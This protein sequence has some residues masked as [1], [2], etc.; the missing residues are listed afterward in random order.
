MRFLLIAAVSLAAFLAAPPAAAAATADL[1]RPQYVCLNKAFPGGWV[2]NDPST[3]TQASID[4]ILAA[5]GGNRGS[6]SRKL[7]VS[8]NAWT[9][10]MSPANETTMLAS[11]DA[12]LALALANEL[13]LSIS[14]DPTQWWD[15]RP[16]LWNWYNKD[17]P[18]FNLNNVYNVEWTG[19]S[20]D[21]ATLISWR[22]WGA[23]F[24]LATPH[25]NFASP[26][27]RE[28][29]AASVAPLA[30]RVAAWYRALP[31]GKKWLL[32]Y[33]RATQELWIGTN[34]FYY[35]NG[36]ALA[37]NDPKDDPSG[38]PG[39]AAVQLGYA[40]VC[41]ASGGS[42]GVP[43]C[44]GAPGDGL[45][46]AQL[47]AVVSSFAAFAA[48]V[49]LDAGIP[50]SRVMV[51]TGAFFGGAPRCNTNCVFN[52]PQAAL[53]QG[54]NPAWSLYGAETSAA[55]NA[56]LP[57]ALGAIGGAA[58][59]ACEWL[60][61]FDAG[62]SESAWSN[63]FEST[64]SFLNNRLIVVQNF[65]SIQKDANATAAVAAVLGGQSCIVD[66]PTALAAN[67]EKKTVVISWTASPTCCVAS[68]ILIVSS[69]GLTLPD[70]IL[71]VPDV[72]TAQLGSDTTHYSLQLPAGV[73]AGE[74]FVQV[75]TYS[76]QGCGGPGQSFTQSVPS[77][78]L[79]VSLA[80]S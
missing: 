51:H 52:S 43:G 4:A 62:H 2:I 80:A 76:M 55:S 34:Y 21:N 56:G 69:M 31:V 15:S 22:N 79:V 68:Q 26:A 13:P 53:V 25:P 9:L 44:S 67:V 36:N 39:G 61:F 11:L 75:V 1:D 70:G 78:A 65:E 12:L 6:A 40:A 77:D 35:S 54:A 17:A 66:A 57:T 20:P 59:G 28:A 33:V 14:I 49:L 41:G 45:S 64:L 48:Q 60:P 29:A 42:G 7:C 73:S 3:F 24:R 50:R 46:V 38:G 18:G 10:I 72:A 74:I 30:A 71:A 37:P 58:W 27:F 32:A 19:P 16:D 5:V 8:F 63:A 23:Q 47:D